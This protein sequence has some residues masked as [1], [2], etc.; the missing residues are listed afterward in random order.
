MVFQDFFTTKF[1]GNHTFLFKSLYLSCLILLVQ[2]LMIMKGTGFNISPQLH[3]LVKF[4]T[5]ISYQGNPHRPS[6]EFHEIKNEDFEHRA[7]IYLDMSMY[8][9]LRK[10]NDGIAWM[11]AK[12]K[13]HGRWDYVIGI[14][15]KNKDGC[16]DG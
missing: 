10:T 3:S 8:H 7:S 5:S 4:L 14:G 1:S 13:N 12:I 9:T 6:E 2:Q 16:G 15:V 11:K